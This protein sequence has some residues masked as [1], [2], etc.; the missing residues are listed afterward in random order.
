[1]S[2]LLEASAVGPAEGTAAAEASERPPTQDQVGGLGKN[3]LLP[4]QFPSI[5]TFPGAS[6]ECLI[7]S[8]GHTVQRLPRFPWPISSE[9]VKELYGDLG[10]ARTGWAI[11]WKLCAQ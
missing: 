1:M 2:K 10:V 8:P 11:Q 7:E 6:Y 5:A 3:R 4:F 9:R